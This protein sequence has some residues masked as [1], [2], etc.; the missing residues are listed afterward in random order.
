MLAVY[1]RCQEDQRAKFDS[2]R[3]EL[4]HAHQAEINEMTS[5]HRDEVSRL[6]RDLENLTR[7]RDEQ[8]LE[9]ESIKQQVSL[10]DVR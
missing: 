6:E 2:Q 5:R 4:D 3:A 10:R 7:S 9:S 8:L 1:F